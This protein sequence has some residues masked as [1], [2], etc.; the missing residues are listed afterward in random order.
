MICWSSLKI[1]IRDEKTSNSKKFGKH[2]LKLEIFFFISRYFGMGS[3]SFCFLQLKC[4]LLDIKILQKK[5]RQILKLLNFF[6]NKIFLNCGRFVCKNVY[7][8]RFICYPVFYSQWTLNIF[9]IRDAAYRTTSFWIASY[10]I[11]FSILW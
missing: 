5:A 11:S 1:T 8:F 9:S 3:D 6:N 10:E 2:K 4:S 7:V